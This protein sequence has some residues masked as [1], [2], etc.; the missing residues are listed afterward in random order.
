MKAIIEEYGSIILVV[1]L[2]TVVMTGSF[3]GIKIWYEDVMPVLEGNKIDLEVREESDLILISKALEFEVGTQVTAADIQT[4]IK[5]YTNTTMAEELEVRVFG[6]TVL[7]NSKPGV[8]Y[9]MYSAE[10]AEGEHISRRGLV[11]FY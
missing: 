7:D 3:Q 11:L 1:I 5:A 2:T 8:Q 9:L 4:E 6:L 10:G